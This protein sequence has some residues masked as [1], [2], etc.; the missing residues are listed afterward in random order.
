VKTISVG[1][2]TVRGE[3]GIVKLLSA[4]M[5]VAVKAASGWVGDAYSESG[6]A[7]QWIVAFASKENAG[8]FQSAMAALRASQNPHLEPLF[9]EAGAKAWKGL[10]GAIVAV[11]A[12]GERVYVLDAPDA[13]SFQAAL[14]RLEG[15]APSVAVFDS[16]RKEWITFGQMI[17]RLL[18]ADLVCIGETHDSEPHHRMQLQI[19][20]ALYACDE[21]LGVGM[22]MFQRPFQKAID[23]Y[24]A[25]K[26]TEEEFLKA[27][28]YEKRWGF[29]WSLYR[30][31]VEFA[32]R[33]GIP[34]AALNARKELTA[35]I[36][37]VGF[38]GLTDEEKKELGDVDL[39]VKEHRAHWF[40]KLGKMHGARTPT[41]EQK[42][43]SYQVMT[44]WDEVMGRSAAEFQQSRKLRRMVVLAGSGHVDLGFGIAGRAVKR[45]GGKAATVHLEVG[46]DGEKL[47]AEAPA[48]FVVIIR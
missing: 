39:Q 36:S 25:G 24:F 46:G 48:D 14:D 30:P 38:D 35:R 44:T 40:E 18:E 16:K 28:E 45:T 31:I 15:A 1:P 21:S 23:D 12:R 13:A 47:A 17:D 2:G 4:D 34:L 6:A 8:E 42:E 19:L 29:A 11:L 10:R 26:G 33:N 32:R 9:D 22:E 5:A 3:F 37:K 41:D 43:R 7:K 20:K 27:T